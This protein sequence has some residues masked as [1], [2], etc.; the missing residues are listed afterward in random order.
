MRGTEGLGTGAL[1]RWS[2]ACFAPQRR[3]GE[4]RVGQTVQFCCWI[5]Q[6]CSL[7]HKAT[8]S[9]GAQL[10]AADRGSLAQ[11][12]RVSSSVLCVLIAFGWFY[13]YDGKFPTIR[14]VGHD[15]VL[16]GFAAEFAVAFGFFQTFLFLSTLNGVACPVHLES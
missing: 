3:P 4:W 6:R 9:S 10:P 7:S 14:K 11:L 13:R 12:N 16:C 8:C 1:V 2:W 5:C 15:W